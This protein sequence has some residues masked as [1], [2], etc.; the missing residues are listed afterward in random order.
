MK[1]YILFKSK[2]N[3][4]LKKIQNLKSKLFHKINPK[5]LISIKLLFIKAYK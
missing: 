3:R 4:S 1:L 2:Y 5:I